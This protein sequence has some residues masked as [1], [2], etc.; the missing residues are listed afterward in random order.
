MPM[1][2]PIDDINA[3]SLLDPEDWQAFRENAHRALDVALN[4]VQ[5]RPNQPVWQEIPDTK[6]A[7]DDP[8][9]LHGSSLASLVG[10][11]QERVLPYTLGNTHPRFWGWV[12]GSGTAGGLVAQM[13]GAAINANMGGRDHGPMYIERQVIQWMCE[14][15]GFPESATGIICTGTSTATLLGLSVARQRTLGPEVR[16]KGYPTGEQLVAYT[17]AE[18]HVS[19]STAMELMGLGTDALRSVPVLEDF[20]LDSALLEKMIADDITAG[21]VPFAVVSALGT[22][23]TGALDDLVAISRICRQQALWHHVDGAFGAL[24][25]LS[26]ALKPRLLGISEADSIAFDFHKWMH[27]GYAAGCLLVRDGELHRQ[28]F[29]SSPAYLQ[30][31]TQGVAAG[32]PWPSDYGIELSRGFSALGVWFQLKE[33]GVQR[34]GRAIY[35]NCLQAQWLGEAVE[36]D[37]TLELMAPVSLNIVCFRYVADHLSVEALNH[38]N[39]RIVVELQVRGIAVPSATVLRGHSAIRVCITNHR[40]RRSDLEAL[41]QAVGGIALE[42]LKRLP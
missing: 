16:R 9:P 41:H 18:S 13:L 37:H 6:K 42:L 33:M 2:E 14:L 40:T 26:E 27:V 4:F 12:H 15:F 21:L 30:S 22:V 28:T 29:E 39:K 32:S 24:A 23:N 20:T 11:V 10:E 17:S 35:R 3:P 5:E 34:L 36:L 19:V 38:L 31:E 1:H 7:V 8:L 25:V